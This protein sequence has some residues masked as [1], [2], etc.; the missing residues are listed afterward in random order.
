MTPNRCSIPSPSILQQGYFSKLLL[1]MA[2]PTDAIGPVEA[3]CHCGAVT[4][5][6][7]SRPSDINECRCTICRRYAAAWAYYDPKEVDIIVK[8]S[9]PTRTYVWGD[10]ELEFHFCSVCGCVTHWKSIQ[11]SR[12]MGINTRMMDPEQFKTVNRRISYGFLS[13]PL[14]SK[15]SAHVE[16]KAQY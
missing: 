12:Q 13:T 14:K 1:A 6:A 15:E 16:D 3:A 5:Q 10:R 7:S 2:T 4:I 8:P 9:A 11:E